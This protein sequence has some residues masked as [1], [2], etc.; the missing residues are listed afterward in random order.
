MSVSRYGRSPG[1]LEASQLVFLSTR[2]FPVQLLAVYR[3]SIL[4]I[5]QIDNLE[6]RAIARHFLYVPLRS[7]LL[8]PLYQYET[9]LEFIGIC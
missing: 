1:S 3:T 2:H 8:P 6:K 9:G 5:I 7:S 4:L